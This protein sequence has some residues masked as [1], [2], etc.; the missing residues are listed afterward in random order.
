[1]CQSLKHPVAQRKLDDLGH[2]EEPTE[3]PKG[4]GSGK[5]EGDDS[6]CSRNFKE[7]ILRKWIHFAEGDPTIG[8]AANQGHN[9]QGETGPCLSSP[10]S[11]T[12]TCS[13]VFTSLFSARMRRP[14]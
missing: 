10:C 7:I 2:S 3:G 14:R 13:L 5:A 11:G 1:M 9:L 6:I 12:G 4:S 8:A